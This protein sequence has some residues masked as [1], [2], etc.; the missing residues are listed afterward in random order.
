[1]HFLTH[2]PFETRVQNQQLPGNS[3]SMTPVVNQGRD[4][5]SK[6]HPRPH[7]TPTPPSGAH[8]LP[9]GS[10]WAPICYAAYPH[11]CSHP[12]PL[13]S[14]TLPAPMPPAP[15]RPRLA[16]VSAHALRATGPPDLPLP[17]VVLLQLAASFEGSISIPPSRSVVALHSLVA[18]TTLV[19]PGIRHP[20]CRPSGACVLPVVYQPPRHTG[21]DL[22]G[23]LRAPRAT[24]P[25]SLI[26]TA[27]PADGEGIA[28]GVSAGP[29]AGHAPWNG[30]VQDLQYCPHHS[31]AEWKAAE[32]R[33]AVNGRGEAGEAALLH[34]GLE[35]D[36]GR[37]QGRRGGY[38][39]AAGL[40]IRLRVTFRARLPASSR[41][42]HSAPGKHRDA[43]AALRC[44][45]YANTSHLS[46]LIFLLLGRQMYD[47]R[48]GRD[49]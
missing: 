28:T 32:R 34:Q 27:Q 30:E 42:A 25:R 46:T 33:W 40:R 20:R 1:M 16:P 35:V 23:S 45:K 18:D 5:E 15:R 2:Q 6:K 7:P 11:S 4:E 14:C 21:C 31:E 8:T 3:S 12:L 17:F 29:N 24:C 47:V 9:R 26:I 39:R 36:K 44:S 41:E 49:R 22:S 43:K 13:P 38:A 10:P 48:S 37:T 19:V